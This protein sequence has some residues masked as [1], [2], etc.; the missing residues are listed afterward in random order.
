MRWFMY[1]VGGR[2]GNDRQGKADVGRHASGE[3]G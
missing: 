3:V 1:P 2:V